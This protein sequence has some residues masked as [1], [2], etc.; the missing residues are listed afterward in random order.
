[1]R[2]FTLWAVLPALLSF[3]ACAQADLDS[4][5]RVWKDSHSN[6][7]E[8]MGAMKI[9]NWEGYLFRDPDSAFI[10]GGQFYDLASSERDTFFMADALNHQAISLTIRGDY[11]N[12]EVYY[13]RTLEMKK[14]INDGPGISSCLSNLGLNA[15][16]KGDLKS[17]EDYQAQSLAMREAAQEA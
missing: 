6:A 2:N 15:Y 10:L 5:W 1:M 12:A 8:R 7:K 11:D 3:G 4:L 14:A 9:L 17:A 16:E 13:L